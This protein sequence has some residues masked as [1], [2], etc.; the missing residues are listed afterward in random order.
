MTG[1]TKFA[2]ANPFYSNIVGTTS[3]EAPLVRRDNNTISNSF[4]KNNYYLPS[5][6]FEDGITKAAKEM[7]KGFGISGGM[8]AAC[9]VADGVVSL[10][11]PPALAAQ[12]L[13]PAIGLTTGGASVLAGAK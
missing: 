8:V 5:Y 4:N 12:S 1:L 7:A 9:Y 3:S 13:C 6:P 11:F 2:F 10:F